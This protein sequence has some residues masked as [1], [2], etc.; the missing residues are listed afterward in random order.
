MKVDSI[1]RDK[2]GTE[3]GYKLHNR[4]NPKEIVCQACRDAHNEWR[5]D[6]HARNPHK[7]TEYGTKYREENREVIRERNKK[8]SPP[9]PEE[10][11]LQNRL[12]RLAKRTIRKEYLEA[13]PTPEYLAKKEAARLKNL[14]YG[15]RQRAQPGYKEAKAAQDKIYRQENRESIQERARLR[16]LAN[17]GAFQQR[18]REYYEANKEHIQAMNRLWRAE[19]PSKRREAERRSRARHF[20]VEYEYYTEQQVYDLYGHTCYLCDT[21]IDMSAA[22]I[23][24]QPGWE[25]GYH[26]DHVVPLSRGGSD[27]LANV[28]PSH[29]VCNLRKGT[30]LLEELDTPVIA[31]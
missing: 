24:G 27:I 9:L 4:A 17:Y 5:R 28:R 12:V 8:Y 14:E 22:R 2:C 7:N 25:Q 3:A 23:V 18:Q 19:N 29:G 16:R 10:Q 11:K 20:G 21:E 15:A 13:Y 30:L 6:Y 31:V 26:L 1:I